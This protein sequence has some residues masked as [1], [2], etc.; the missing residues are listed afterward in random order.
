MSTRLI[1]SAP[2]GKIHI[3][4]IALQSIDQPQPI[5]NRTMM[6][7]WTRATPRHVP[8][9]DAWFMTPQGPRQ[10]RI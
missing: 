6:I 8:T 10:I 4:L 1:R 7:P 9:L 3:F 5:P 2:V